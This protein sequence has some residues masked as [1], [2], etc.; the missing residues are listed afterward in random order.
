[1]NLY[2]ILRQE[3]NKM[4]ITISC[5]ASE[6]NITEDILRD[7]FDGKAPWMLSEALKVCRLLN[8]SDI[9]LLF[10]QFDNNS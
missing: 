9:K 8:Y 6:L 3:M 2:P 1:M 7:K 4:G 5:L 10:L